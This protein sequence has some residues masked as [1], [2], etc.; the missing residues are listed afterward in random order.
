MTDKSLKRML[1]KRARTE[2]ESFKD[3]IEL[4]KRGDMYKVDFHFL[5]HRVQKSL[6]TDDLEQAKVNLEIFK[7]KYIDVHLKMYDSGTNLEEAQKAYDKYSKALSR[8]L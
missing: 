1:R 4:K 7:E 8:I 2:W 5:S 3:T 6:M